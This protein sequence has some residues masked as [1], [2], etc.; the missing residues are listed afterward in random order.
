MKK[1]LLTG[2][3]RWAVVALTSILVTVGTAA[4]TPVAFDVTMMHQMAVMD[5]QMATA[6][7]NGDSDHDFAAMMIPHHE[8]AIAMARLELR[9]GTDPILRRLAEEI[10]VTQ[11]QEIMVMQRQLRQ[12]A[13]HTASKSR[14]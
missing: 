1:F 9:S 5:H 13:I 3:H 2:G 11:Q 8:G 12:E 7:M 14:K 10:I 6:P 4:A